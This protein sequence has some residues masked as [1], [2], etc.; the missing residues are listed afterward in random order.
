M[1]FAINQLLSSSEVKIKSISH[2]PKV[3]V[4]SKSSYMQRI[5]IFRRGISPYLRRFSDATL[6]KKRGVDGHTPLAH[7]LW[8]QVVKGGD[9]V[10]DATCGN[11]HDSLVLADLALTRDSGLL[12]CIDVQDKAID[13]TRE[14]FL[15]AGYINS[16]Q[17]E[18]IKFVHGSHA[19]FPLEIKQDSVSAIIF[20][21]GYLPGTHGD[22]DNRITTTTEVTM[23]AIANALP[24]LKIGGLLSVMLYRGHPEGARESDA[25]LDF[26]QKM[27]IGQWK[28]FTHTPLNTAKGPI[29][30]TVA[31]RQSQIPDVPM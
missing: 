17:D 28:V 18:R 19:D 22:G 20:N 26:F 3:D 24:L 14:K 30:V 8:S 25:C 27:K 29:L 2:L 31:R 16:F 5:F 23:K 9:I 7:L 21:L 11:G 6:K 12:Y 4:Y 15:A 1:S 10:I 13:S